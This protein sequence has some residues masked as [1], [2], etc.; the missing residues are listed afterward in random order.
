MAGNLKVGNIESNS[1]RII[2]TNDIGSRSMGGGGSYVF[3]NKFI[4][5]KFDFLY[6]GTSQ[7]N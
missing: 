1:G 2:E 3:R 5:G 4:D 6:E 7:N